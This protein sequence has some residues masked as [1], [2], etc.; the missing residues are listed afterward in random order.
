MTSTLKTSIS[1]ITL[2]YKRKVRA[3]DSPKVSCSEDVYRLFRENWDD[4]TINLFEEFKILLVDRS[5]RCL[6]AVV[7]SKGG[8]SGTLVDPKLVFAS[9]L[10]ARACGLIL[11]HNHPSGNLAPS[12]QDIRL[13]EKLMRAG[14]YLD[15]RIL[16]H[17]IITDDDY[18]SLA[19]NDL[20]SFTL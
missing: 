2:N 8:I 11:G 10:K 9:A 20:M 18:T 6:G 4:L 14:S 19:D 1:E 12:Q 3:E 16:D 5:N 15:L 17:L 7:I 13:T